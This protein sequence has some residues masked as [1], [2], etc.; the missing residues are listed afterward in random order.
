MLSKILILLFAVVSALASHANACQAQK[1]SKR[2][3]CYFASWA[4]YRKAPADMQ[5]SKLD[6]CLCTHVLYAFVP[7]S[8]DALAPAQLDIGK[9]NSLG[10]ISYC[11]KKKF[12]IIYL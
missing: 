6:P 12:S 3:I 9:A 11:Y 7:I 10:L 2:M 8:N 5:V 4:M 1:S